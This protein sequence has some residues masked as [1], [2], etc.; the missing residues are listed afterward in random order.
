MDSVM[1]QHTD[2]FLGKWNPS[3]LLFRYGM[4]KHPNKVSL[5]RSVSV[6]RLND[7]PGKLTSCMEEGPHSL[8]VPVGFLLWW[9]NFLFLC[10][11]FQVCLPQEPVS[12]IM[13]VSLLSFFKFPF[14]RQSEKFGFEVA[15]SRVVSYRQNPRKYTLKQALEVVEIRGH[16]KSCRSY[17][18]S[19]L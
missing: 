16:F 8:R 18:D 4:R 13:S 12:G 5:M 19:L 2:C 6:Y 1:I 15:G 14:T 11:V 10:K 3:F 9:C 7:R 17:S